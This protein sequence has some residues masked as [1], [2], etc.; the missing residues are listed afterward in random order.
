MEPRKFHLHL[1]KCSRGS[2]Y[3]KIKNTDFILGYSAGDNSHYM[4]DISVLDE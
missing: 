3:E 1:G 2:R 4:A